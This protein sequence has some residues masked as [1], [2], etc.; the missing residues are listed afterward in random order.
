M[1]GHLN[2]TYLHAMGPHGIFDRGSFYFRERNWTVSEMA[3][4]MTDIAKRSV[5]YYFSKY[6]ERRF[7]PES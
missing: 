3:V 4:V 7:L 2:R 1:F 5:Q 6:S